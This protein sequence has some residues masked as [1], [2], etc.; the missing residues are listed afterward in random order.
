M[1]DLQYFL[2]N[3]KNKM[4]ILRFKATILLKINR[5]GLEREKYITI[6]ILIN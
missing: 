2:A 3:S 1:V 6:S 4:I 5:S